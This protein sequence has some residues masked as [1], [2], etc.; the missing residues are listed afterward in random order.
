MWHT[1]GKLSRGC[2]KR[3][4]G[5]GRMA[6]GMYNSEET[7]GSAAVPAEPTFFLGRPFFLLQPS[8]VA[9]YQVLYWQNIPSQIKAWDEVD[10]VRLELSAR[11]MDRIDRAAQAQGLTSADDYLAQWRWGEELERPGNAQAVAEA[12]QQELERTL[13]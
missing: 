9:T 2:A 3:C 7:P 8:L 5:V 6:G 4:V 1:G 12:L 13:T 10:E 11:A